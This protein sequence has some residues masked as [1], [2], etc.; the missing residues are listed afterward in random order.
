MAFKQIFVLVIFA[1]A[2]DALKWENC[3]GSSPVNINEIQLKPTPVVVKPGA[4]VTFGGRFTVAGAAGTH[5]ELD[6]TLWKSGWWGTWIRVFCFGHCNRDIGCADLVK[7][8]EGAQCP[9][10]NGEY[11]V[12][13][14]T[15]KLPDVSV[16]SFIK[17]GKYKIKAD[18]RDK[19]NN[20]RISCL[21]AE[22]EIR[23]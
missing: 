4:E 10:Q 17:N 8:L 9:L 7:L 2:V 20:R 18:L 22:V 23:S 15:H 5:Y 11:V 6:V 19:G 14:Q 13:T 3:D 12:K 21:E 16:P 1:F